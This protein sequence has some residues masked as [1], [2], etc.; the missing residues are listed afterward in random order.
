ME[1]SIDYLFEIKF[2]GIGIDFEDPEAM[3]KDGVTFK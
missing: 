2:K 3:D 1:I